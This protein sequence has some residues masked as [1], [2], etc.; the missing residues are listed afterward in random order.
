VGVDASL[1]G[2]LERVGV[3]H[4]RPGLRRKK[5]ELSHSNESTN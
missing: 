2:P 4:W 3:Y 5:H 1:A